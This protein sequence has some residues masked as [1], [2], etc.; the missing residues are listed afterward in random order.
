MSFSERIAFVTGASQGIGRACAL[1]LATAGTTVAVAARNQDKLNELV[2]E[3]TAGGGKA[4]AFALD[5]TDEDQIKSAIKAARKSLRNAARNQADRLGIQ[6][7]PTIVVEG[8]LISG[9][10]PPAVFAHALRSA[11]Q[12]RAA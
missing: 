6:S 4:A 11:V 1:K 12:R 7:V 10:Q 8:E 5:V 3:I 9:A 2:G